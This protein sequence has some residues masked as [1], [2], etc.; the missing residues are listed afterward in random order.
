MI[1][2]LQFERA[3]R[4]RGTLDQQLYNELTRMNKASRIVRKQ[5]PNRKLLKR[6]RKA[7]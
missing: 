4:G 7:G 1:Y 6:A 5:V 2:I 3:K